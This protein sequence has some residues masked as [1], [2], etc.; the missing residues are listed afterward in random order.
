[1]KLFICSTFQPVPPPICPSQSL[2]MNLCS[3]DS[4]RPRLGAEKSGQPQHGAL[5]VLPLDPTC[6]LAPGGAELEWHR[7]RWLALCRSSPTLG[8]HLNA[9]ESSDSA[10][11]SILLASSAITCVR[12]QEAPV[13]E[14]QVRFYAA[15]GWLCLVPRLESKGEN[16]RE[17]QSK[18]TQRQSQL[19]KRVTGDIR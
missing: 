8:K 16:G 7:R 2:A 14:L 5:T 6:P 15:W 1:M 12:F 13:N 18:D 3:Q 4:H 17:E 11:Q 10:Y 19:L 9:H